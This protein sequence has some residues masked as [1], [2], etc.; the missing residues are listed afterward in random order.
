[1][2]KS[3]LFLIFCSVFVFQVSFASRID[4]AFDALKQF[5]YF[6]AKKLFYASMKHHKA[7]AC[8]GLTIIY[9]RNDNPFHQL[10]S[11]Y[12]NILRADSLYPKLTIKAKDK[13]AIHQV[14][15]F[16][17]NALKEQVSTA[18]FKVELQH[19]TENTLNAFL[20]KHPWS[21][22][23]FK[24]IH[25][26]DS[27]AYDQALQ[28]HTA[29]ALSEFLAKY[30]ATEYLNQAKVNFNIR[31]F[32]EETK[33]GTLTD[34]I[35]FEKNF[36]TNPH[37]LEAQDSIFK[38]STK[39]NTVDAYKQFIRS[40]SANRNN[41]IAWRKLYLAYTSEYAVDLLQN[42]QR[43]FPDYPFKDE[44]NRE[45]Q[46][47]NA[48]LIPYKYNNKFGWMD[49][50]GVPVITA[51][52]SS[53]GFFKEDLAWVEMEGKYGFVN[54]A[55]E[56]V[57]PCQFS[58]VTD[59]EKGRAIVEIAEKYG[60]IDRNGKYII[61]V[62]YED[63][64]TYTE[65]LHYMQ[66]DGVYGYI[67]GKGKTLIA[68]QFD[69]AYS[70][71]NG[72]AF[73]K[74]N[75]KTGIIDSYGAYV[76]Q[77]EFDEVALFTDSLYVLKNEGKIIFLT[78]NQRIKASYVAEEIGKLVADRAVIVQNNKVGYVDA[79][80]SLVI[81]FSFD[82]FPNIVFEGEF[83]GN[84]AKVSKGQK[85]GVIDRLGKIIIPIQHQGLGKV[86]GLIACQKAGK[87]G[88]I[89]LTNKFVLQP[90]YDAA[91]SFV[92]GLAQVRLL[93]FVGI[94]TSKGQ[95]LFPIQF[96]SLSKLTEQLYVTEKDGLFGIYKM[97]G[98][99]VVPN[100]YQQIR[101]IQPNLL[102]MSKGNELHYFQLDSQT[103]IQPQLN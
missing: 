86:S 48:V 80:G 15:S 22:E 55:N 84:Y 8:Y 14:N 41:E 102:L 44:L 34:Y 51:Q 5:D 71:S 47:A 4:N 9:L 69:E 92:N 53:V 87:W 49:L 11:A 42:F 73:V 23:K 28:L 82:A 29:V 58:S 65:G 25:L 83:D 68:P 43:E 101:K 38:L 60:C 63:L 57:I 36:P 45:Q 75:N 93:D 37:V 17:I 79:Q 96:A 27:I 19:P 98:Q 35:N 97:N 26:R 12:S 54:K 76:L 7:A 72:K 13:L 91:T 70:F 90:T 77:P 6:K 39:E 61:P 85:Y 66:I 94:I 59:F 46:L 52:Y 33:N 18:F 62:I 16:A 50:K 3:K 2:S 89:D 21:Q 64:G 40:F 88:F 24:A 81:P 31:Q 30:P 99:L 56:L 67:D 95:T 20:I 103:I 100:E 74:L 10:D 78:M 1:M 32:E